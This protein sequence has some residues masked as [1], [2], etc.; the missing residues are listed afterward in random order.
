MNPP[1]EVQDEARAVGAR[2]RRLYDC[3]PTDATS[4]ECWTEEAMTMS[5]SWSPA[6]C[7][8]LPHG[9]WHWLSDAEVRL[10]N[11]VYARAQNDWMKD[12]IAWLESGTQGPWQRGQLPGMPSAGCLWITVLAVLAAAALVAYLLGSHPVRTEQLRDEARSP[13]L[14]ALEQEI[15][16]GIGS[17]R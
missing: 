17:G 2:L 6:L 1:A 10:D 8:L 12:V 14:A 4:L 16:T 13:R 11:Q 5:E 3:P 9:V 7:D 15:A